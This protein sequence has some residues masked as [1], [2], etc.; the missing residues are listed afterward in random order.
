MYLPEVYRWCSRERTLQ[1]CSV[2]V[3]VTR[4]HRCS[5]A[6]QFWW[7]RSGISTGYLCRLQS[8]MYAKA[9]FHRPPALAGRAS[10]REMRWDCNTKLNWNLILPFALN[11]HNLADQ[12]LFWRLLIFFWKIFWRK[13]AKFLRFRLRG[14]CGICRSREELSNREFCRKN[15]RRYSRERT[16]KYVFQIG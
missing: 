16:E 13:Y 15:R 11:W 9:K 7:I 6:R 2:C 5:F 14:E 12:Y 10:F 3:I 1:S 4:R 8:A